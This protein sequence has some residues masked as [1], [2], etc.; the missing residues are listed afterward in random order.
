M[1]KLTLLNA[2]FAIKKLESY[3]KICLM[4]G[5]LNLPALLDDLS[6]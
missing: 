3:N 4:Q 2:V 5:M 1:A 6:L